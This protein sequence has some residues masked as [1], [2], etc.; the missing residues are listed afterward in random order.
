MHA[1]LGLKPGIRVALI[2]APA[3]LERLV[4][5]LDFEVSI[6]EEPDSRTEAAF[7]FVRSP[8]EV[9]GGLSWIAPRL[10]KKP[11]IWIFYRK[12][13]KGVSWTSLSESAAIYGL[14][15]YKVMSL[16]AEW[17][18]VAFGAARVKA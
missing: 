16:N 8:D 12:G 17:T 13:K 7:W 4:P 10:G 1:K 11:R 9:E 14:A 3:E 5:D 15:Q 6:A 18:G 2:G